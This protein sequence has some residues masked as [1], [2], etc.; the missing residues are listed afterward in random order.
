M[1]LLENVLEIFGGAPARRIML[2]HVAKAPGELR[3][4]FAVAGLTLPLDRQMGRLQKLGA[5]DECDARSADDVHGRIHRLESG[6]RSLG[7]RL[8]WHMR[9]VR[10]GWLTTP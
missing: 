8:K 6:V 3:D 5:G 7:A 1:T 10:G 9:N 4:S 2:A